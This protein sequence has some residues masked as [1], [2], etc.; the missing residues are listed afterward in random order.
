MRIEKLSFIERNKYINLKNPKISYYSNKSNYF[1]WVIICDKCVAV[2]L[3]Q[4]LKKKI[5][6]IYQILLV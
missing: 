1:P 2:K 6:S 4:H 5:Q 3:K